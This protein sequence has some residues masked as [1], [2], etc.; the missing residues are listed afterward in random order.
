MVSVKEFFSDPANR[1]LIKN[2]GHITEVNLD[3]LRDRLITALNKLDK[4]GVSTTSLR[5]RISAAITETELNQINTE[6][7]ALIE[8]NKPGQGNGKPI[9]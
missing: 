6:V 3:K 7:Q 9:K 4:Q 5:T 8:A 2:Y 1:A